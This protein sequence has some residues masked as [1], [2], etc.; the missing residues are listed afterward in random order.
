ML[1]HVGEVPLR[2]QATVD[3]L[4]GWLGASLIGTFARDS[5][6]PN[7]TLTGVS[8]RGVILRA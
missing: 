3:A 7:E 5:A 4:T 6:G 1:A 8:W 2:R